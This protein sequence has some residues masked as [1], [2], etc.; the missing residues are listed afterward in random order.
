MPIY[1]KCLYSL[2]EEFDFTI[3]ISKKY[4]FGDELMK[5]PVVF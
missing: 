1:L 5:I 2:P 4:W 3:C